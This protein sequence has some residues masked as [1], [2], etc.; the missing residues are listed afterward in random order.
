MGPG[1]SAYYHNNEHKYLDH[2]GIG[3]LVSYLKI[4]G[5]IMKHSA[6]EMTLK[7]IYLD[8]L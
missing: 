3:I 4:K 1:A 6:T 7:V 2:C 8:N 5:I